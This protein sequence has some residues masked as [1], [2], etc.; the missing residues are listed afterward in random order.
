MVVS[1]C[2]SNFSVY[3]LLIQFLFLFLQQN[4]KHRRK[5][6]S[7]LSAAVNLRNEARKLA[8]VNF[9]VEN[10]SLLLLVDT[11]FSLLV[12]GKS[13]NNGIWEETANIIVA[14]PLMRNGILS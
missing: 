5:H 1:S 2:I 7:A 4:S 6:Q 3:I 8:I 9:V 12:S 14:I 13:L 10:P 11:T